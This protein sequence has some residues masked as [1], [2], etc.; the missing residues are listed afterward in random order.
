MVRRRSGLGPHARWR[1][2]FGAK[3]L[4]ILTRERKKERE[5]KK[6][7]ERERWRE[8]RREREKK[9]DN[10]SFMEEIIYD[11]KRIK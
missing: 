11:L 2:W 6:G 5:R 7:R 1:S 4:I 10:T 9:R 3:R 8:R